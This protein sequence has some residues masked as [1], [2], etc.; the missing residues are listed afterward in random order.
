M[1]DG[2]SEHDIEFP[3][4]STTAYGYLERPAGGR[5]LRRARAGSPRQ[6]RHPPRRRGRADHPTGLEETTPSTVGAIGFPQGV[7][8]E[9]ITADAQGH[10]ARQDEMLGIDDARAAFQRLEATLAWEHATAFL[11]EH[12]R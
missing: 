10:Y 6:P 9:K 8:P 5:G 11:R 3:T 12:V 4:N 1:P 7:E 2:H